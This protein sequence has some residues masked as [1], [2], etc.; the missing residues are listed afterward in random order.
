MERAA[1]KKKVK[2]LLEKIKLINDTPHSIAMGVTCSV[3]AAFTPFF[4]FKTII[5][6]VLAR[7][8]RGNITAA[9]ITMGL[10]AI[11]IIIP[12]AAMYPQ[13]EVGV[14]LLRTKDEVPPEFFTSDKL[15]LTYLWHNMKSVGAPLLV[16]SL[17]TSFLLSLAVYPITLNIIIKIRERMAKKAH[18]DPIPESVD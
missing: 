3:F 16:G 15:N 12:I 9:L 10:F 1:M 17:L 2:A 14:I 8:L 4:F 13:Y 7:L 6:V 5:A 18:T 11:L